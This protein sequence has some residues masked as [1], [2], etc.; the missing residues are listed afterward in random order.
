MPLINTIHVGT[1]LSHGAEWIANEN[2]EKVRS[3]GK[4]RVRR[5]MRNM[6]LMVQYTNWFKVLGTTTSSEKH[7]PS[8]D[9]VKRKFYSEEPNSLWLSDVSNL[10]STGAKL[11]VIAIKDQASHRILGL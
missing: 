9:L 4:E 1:G 7:H 3:I 5:L 10:P 8:S 6:R 2:R 11:Y